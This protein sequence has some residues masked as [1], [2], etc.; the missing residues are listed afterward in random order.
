MAAIF[1]APSAEILH[2]R[3]L[4]PA[5]PAAV[6]PAIC[7]VLLSPQDARVSLCLF[8]PHHTQFPVVALAGQPDCVPK[9]LFRSPWLTGCAAAE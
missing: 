3:A 9:V 2:R 4:H 7:S 5:C 1:G 8:C 6:V